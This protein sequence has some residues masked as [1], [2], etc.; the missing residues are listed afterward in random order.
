MPSNS[1]TKSQINLYNFTINMIQFKII[2]KE[3]HYKSI[4]QYAVYEK[5]KVKY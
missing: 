2:L 4:Q 5:Y 1:K 3:I